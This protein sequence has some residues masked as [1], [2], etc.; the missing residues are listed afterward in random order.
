MQNNVTDSGCI[1]LTVVGWGIQFIWAIYKALGVDSVRAA[2]TCPAN[3]SGTFSLLRDRGQHLHRAA[4]SRKTRTA[5]RL[6][7]LSGDSPSACP[8]MSRAWA[9]ANPGHWHLEPC[10]RRLQLHTPTNSTKSTF[11][12][13][14]VSPLIPLKC[15]H[16][17]V[18]GASESWKIKTFAHK[19]T[20]A[21]NML[22]ELTRPLSLYHCSS[23]PNCPHCERS[24]IVPCKSLKTCR[25][26][27]QCSQGEGAQKTA[28]HQ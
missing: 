5:L 15:V 3:L 17:I 9:A 22:E 16:Q 2:E 8:A 24:L 11:F 26:R 28:A 18:C 7:S 12:A 14:D 1:F 6:Q 13:G 23:A 4:K 19:Y 21:H 10:P 20:Q 27:V 25:P